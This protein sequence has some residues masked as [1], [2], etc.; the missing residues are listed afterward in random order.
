MY[1]LHLYKDYFPV[2]GGIENYVRLLAEGQAAQGHRVEVLVNN[3]G[4]RTLHQHQNGVK[5]TKVGRWLH[6]A[7]T[8]LSPRYPFELYRR[9]YQAHP[10]DIIHLHF[11]YPISEISW[12]LGSYLPSFGRKRPRCVITYHSDIVR[13]QRLLKFYAPILGRILQRADL[14]LPTS[15]NYIQSSPFLREVA[16]K[17]RSVPL[18]IDCQRFLEPDS[19][20]VAAIRQQYPG[21]ILLAGGRLRY[22]KGLQYL[23]AAMPEVENARL[24]IVGVGP[25]EAELRQQTTRLGLNQRVIFLGEVSDKDL[26]NYYAACDLFVFPSSERSEAFG[27]M[28]VEAMASARAVISTELGTGTSYVNLNGETGLVVPPANPAALALAITQLLADES[29]RREMG[30]RGRARVLAEFTADKTLSRVEEVYLE[31]L[32]EKEQEA[33]SKNKKF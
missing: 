8:P 23:L 27:L 4:W 12:L 29:T 1:I 31:V 22:Y 24:L 13:Q 9:L 18:G 11:P 3:T 28:Q 26:P 21:P 20:R 19:E 17:C 10:P 6:L 2:L 32:R 7:S 16:E 25:M 15:P 14:I 5:I 30:Q 33:R